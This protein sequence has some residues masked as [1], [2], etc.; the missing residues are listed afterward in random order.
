MR[1]LDQAGV[2][3]AA[4]ILALVCVGS[5]LGA[6]DPASAAT[7]M[8]QDPV[9]ADIGKLKQFHAPAKEAAQRLIEAGSEVVPRLNQALLDPA[10]N[11][12]QRVQ[13]IGVLAEIGEAE[14]VDVIVQA[15]N[16]FWQ[17]PAI[18]ADALRVLGDLPQT[19]A[20]VALAIRVLDDPEEYHQVQRRGLAYFGQQRDETGRRFIEPNL[21]SAEPGLQAAALYLAARLGDAAVRP[22]I[23]A[24]LA[25]P[26]P[27]SLKHGL[28]MALAELTAPAELEQL[29]PAAMRSSEEYAGALRIAALRSAAPGEK[30]ARARELVD[31]KSPYEQKIGARYLAE[32]LGPEALSEYLGA[33]AAPGAR[34]VARHQLRRDGYRVD[35]RGGKVKIERNESR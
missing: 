9:A 30:E 33:G 21:A 29:T 26:P 18:R 12:H 32:N 11:D 27:P 28:L 22:R 1:P 14:S 20:A 16:T 2:R 17:Q 34:A 7:A 3:V 23:V 10:S 25:G 19:P 4:T 15:A 24:M 35:T 6:A 8:A 13:L 5:V 31:S